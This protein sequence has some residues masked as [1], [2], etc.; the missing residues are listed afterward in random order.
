MT[1]TILTRLTEL[2]EANTRRRTLWRELS[3]YTTASDRSDI[4]AA[5]ARCDEAGD[6]PA[7]GQVR[8]ILIAQRSG[9]TA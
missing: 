4:A 8:R 9:A 6:D 1:S 5:V 3:S 2:R 7:T